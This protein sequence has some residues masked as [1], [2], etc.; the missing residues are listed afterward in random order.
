M[1]ANPS[2]DVVERLRARGDLAARHTPQGVLPERIFNEAADLI[3]AQATELA[4]LRERVAEITGQYA[5]I[6]DRNADLR[7]HAD[8]MVGALDGCHEVMHETTAVLTASDCAEV[9][10]QMTAA[11]AAIT[12]Y[13]ESGK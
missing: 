8:A 4:T 2:A 5:T 6:C 3:E 7:A 11:R 9:A 13:Q 10:K 12:A 1:T